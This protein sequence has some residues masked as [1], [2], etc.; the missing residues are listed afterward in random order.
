M[1]RQ[2]AT[3]LELFL[4]QENVVSQVTDVVWR[5]SWIQVVR[6]VMRGE[7]RFGLLYQDIYTGL[8]GLAREQIRVFY[9]SHTRY[10]THM[11]MLHSQRASLQ[12][13]REQTLFSMHREPEGTALLREL[14]LGRWVPHPSLEMIE[15]IVSVS[16]PLG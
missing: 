5:P 7:V 14:R 13:T 10:A 6:A 4:L 11:M 16:V 3:H 12:E 15:R 8:S 9:E 1:N 2:F